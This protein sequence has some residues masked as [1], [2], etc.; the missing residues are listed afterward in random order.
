MHP[1]NDDGFERIARW[2]EQGVLIHTVE[3][4]LTALSTFYSRALTRL[5]GR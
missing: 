2:I 5:K 1:A 3:T 4:D